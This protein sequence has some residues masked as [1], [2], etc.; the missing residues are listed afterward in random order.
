MNWLSILSATDSELRHRF[1]ALKRYLDL[2]FELDPIQHRTSEG[3]LCLR[4][5]NQRLFVNP[6]T[7]DMSCDLTAGVS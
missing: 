5:L 4:T 1:P 7:G 3:R 2:G 6:T